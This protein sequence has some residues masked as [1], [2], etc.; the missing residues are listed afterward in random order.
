[1]G[2]LTESMTRL[3]D[4]ILAW[5]HMREAFCHQL[6]RQAQER[7]THMYALCAAFARDRDGARRAWSED[8]PGRPDTPQPRPPRKGHKKPRERFGNAG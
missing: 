7:R 5:R 1:M 3:R 4:E 2:P 6:A 8:S